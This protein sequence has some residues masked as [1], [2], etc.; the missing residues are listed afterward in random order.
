[1]PKYYAG[2]GSRSTPPDICQLMAQIAEELSE[3]GYILRS[4]HA[5]GADIAFEN[6]A[7]EQKQIFLPWD[8]FNGAWINDRTYFSVRGYS[9]AFD[10]AQKFHPVWDRCNYDAKC[11]LARNTHQI[12]GKDY[13]EPAEFVVCWTPNGSGSGGT[14]QALRIAKSMNIPI[15]DLAIEG[16]LEELI[17][18][19]SNQGE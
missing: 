1:M 12:M 4:G 15:F 3:R 5:R 14:G 6:G 7:K 19:V 18:F 2:I 8:S 10:I 9:R 17:E 13:D 16:K 11:L